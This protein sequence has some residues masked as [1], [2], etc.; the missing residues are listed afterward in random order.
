MGQW[1]NQEAA[2]PDLKSS[3]TAYFITV[4]LDK[5]AKSY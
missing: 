5:A 4:L 2:G 3:S 1:Q